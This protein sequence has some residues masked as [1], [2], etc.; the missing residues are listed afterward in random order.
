MADFYVERNNNKW[1]LKNTFSFFFSFAVSVSA[2][3]FCYLLLFRRTKY[4]KEQNL[5]TVKIRFFQR[6][7][8]KER[9]RWCFKIF[10]FSLF[11]ESLLRLCI[12]MLLFLFHDYTVRCSLFKSCLYTSM[13]VERNEWC[14]YSFCSLKNSAYIQHANIKQ[15]AFY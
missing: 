2:F 15:D 6:L 14:I 4:K 12:D 10:S 3:S 7:I 9:R 11:Y 13:C 8:N 5:S 1:H